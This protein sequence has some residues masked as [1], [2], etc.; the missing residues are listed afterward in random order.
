MVLTQPRRQVLRGLVLC[1]VL[2]LVHSQAAAT[3]TP[4]AAPTALPSLSPT[5]APTPIGNI[6]D[7]LTAEPI[8]VPEDA[9]RAYS[10]FVELVRSN[11]WVM[12]RL[13]VWGTRNDPVTILVPT[14]FAML[15]LNHSGVE[16]TQGVIENHIFDGLLTTSALRSMVSITSWSGQNFTVFTTRDGGS[17]TLK[18][19]LGNSSVTHSILVDTN[20]SMSTGFGVVHGIDRALFT[21]SQMPTTTV[22]PG[23]STDEDDSEWTPE[24]ITMVIIGI[25]LVVGIIAI[26]AIAYVREKRIVEGTTS[27]KPN[28]DMQLPPKYR[29]PSNYS[30]NEY[31]SAFSSQ[32]YRPADSDSA[33]SGKG[34]YSAGYFDPNPNRDGLN[35]QTSASDMYRESASRIGGFRRPSKASLIDEL[36]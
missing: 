16:V 6:I 3:S 23:Q 26:T 35:R 14:N 13:D 21:E 30:R 32:P 8:E 22:I 9:N 34:P 36:S 4:S 7:A 12:R 15:D 18:F 25:I 31:N 29:E 24:I 28:R 27:P 17:S 19:S 10:T 20:A 1:L 33:Y 5:T 11:D 2:G